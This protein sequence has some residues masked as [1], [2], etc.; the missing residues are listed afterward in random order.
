MAWSGPT[1]SPVSAT[2]RAKERP[3]A[4]TRGG[5]TA[6]RRQGVQRQRSNRLVLGD[7]RLI[8]KDEGALEA[9]RIGGD[10]SKREDRTW[11]QVGSRT[12]DRRLAQIRNP[13]HERSRASGRDRVKTMW[14]E[15]I[16]D[17]LEGKAD[18]VLN[19]ITVDTS[20][21]EVRRRDSTRAPIDSR[22]PA[23]T[24]RTPRRPAPAFDPGARRAA[25]SAS[26]CF[27]LRRSRWEVLLCSARRIA[28]LLLRVRYL[29]AAATSLPLTRCLGEELLAVLPQV[30]LD[31]VDPW[32]RPEWDPGCGG[33][34]IQ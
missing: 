19:H 33:L 5:E 20:A 25:A 10:P 26:R 30:A 1:R 18:A 17:W 13:P 6:R 21:R 32:R 8:I 24:A 4:L 11:S 31:A 7:A 3:V 29:R 23:R 15:T 12:I 27:P 16:L 34:V 14:P 28:S 9:V 22:V 2:L